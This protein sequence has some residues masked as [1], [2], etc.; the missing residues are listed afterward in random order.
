MISEGQNTFGLKTESFLK[1]VLRFC[2]PF[3]YLKILL[4]MHL[5][6]KGK[7]SY[8]PKEGRFLCKADIK[9]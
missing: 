5:Q 2:D 6:M 9:R 7:I 8:V 1:M 3:L 4:Q